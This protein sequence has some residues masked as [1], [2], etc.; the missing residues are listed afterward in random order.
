MGTSR[1]WCVLGVPHTRPCPCTGVTEATIAARRLVRSIRL[2]RRA[3]IS[4][5]RTSRPHLPLSVLAHA[6]VSESVSSRSAAHSN[7]IIARGDFGGLP[8]IVADAEEVEV[9]VA[10]HKRATLRV[11]NVFLTVDADRAPT[12]IEAGD[13]PLCGRAARSWL[14]PAGGAPHQLSPSL[15]VV[16]PLRPSAGRSPQAVARRGRVPRRA[17]GPPQLADSPPL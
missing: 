17:A 4:P 3:A 10:Q 6:D 8:A 15:R 12:D 5:N 9:V 7:P 13:T 1:R 14:D 2:I 11:G 16:L